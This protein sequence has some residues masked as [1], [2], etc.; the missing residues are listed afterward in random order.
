MISV[1]T[2]YTQDQC[3]PLYYRRLTDL[4]MIDLIERIFENNIWTKEVCANVIS[5]RLCE[6]LRRFW[7]HDRVIIGDVRLLC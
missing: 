3:I 4:I 1:D 2:H 7:R 5:L 6:I